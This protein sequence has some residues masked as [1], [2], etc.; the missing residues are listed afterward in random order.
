MLVKTILTYEYD[1]ALDIK[2]MKMAQLT[3][4]PPTSRHILVIAQGHL[5]IAQGHLVIAQ[6]HFVIAQGHLVISAVLYD[7]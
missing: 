7:F 1:C 6:G 4:P 2:R 5:V 3:M